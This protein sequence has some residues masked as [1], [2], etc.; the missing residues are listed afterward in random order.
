[1]IALRATGSS[2]RLWGVNASSMTTLLYTIDRGGLFPPASIFFALIAFDPLDAL[3]VDAVQHHRQLAGPQ[4]HRLCPLLDLWKLERAF[5][6][7]LVPKGV[8]VGVPVED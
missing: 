5:L 1:M 3:E 4:L 8:A 6:Q 7:P 2:G